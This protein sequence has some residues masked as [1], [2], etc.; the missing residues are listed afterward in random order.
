M[1]LDLAKEGEA[2][3]AEAAVDALIRLSPKDVVPQIVSRLEAAS[4]D[5]ITDERYLTMMTLVAAA[6]QLGEAGRPALYSLKRIIAREDT[7]FVREEARAAIDT[8]LGDHGE[9]R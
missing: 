9:R 6:G 7:E 2:L 1:L 3:V 8:I 5:T 4:R